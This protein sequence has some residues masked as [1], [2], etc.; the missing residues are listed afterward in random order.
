[1]GWLGRVFQQTGTAWTKAL[2]GKRAGCVPGH[3]RWCQNREST[4]GGWGKEGR[5]GLGE[6]DA[7]EAF[8]ATQRDLDFSLRITGH[9]QAFLT[10]GNRPGAAEDSSD[11]CDRNKVALEVNRSSLQW[12]RQER[13]GAWTRAKAAEVEERDASER[14]LKWQ[15]GTTWYELKGGVGDGCWVPRV[16]PPFLHMEPQGAVLFLELGLTQEG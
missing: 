11:G 2:W 12:C 15:V 1:M 13:T 7:L 8:Q 4:R 6:L 5:R 9:H 14:G 3:G 10:L 16:T